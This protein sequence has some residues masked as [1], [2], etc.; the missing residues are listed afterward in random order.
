[1]AIKGNRRNLCDRNV[2]YLGCINVSNV[3]VCTSSP[4]YHLGNLGLERRIALHYYNFAC[5]SKKK[6]LF[7]YFVFLGPH[8]RHTE[9]PRLGLESEL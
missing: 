7:I 5:E 1:M 9:V 6:S 4:R 3:V 8:L 2:W